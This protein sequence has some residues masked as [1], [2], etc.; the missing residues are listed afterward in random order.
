VKSLVYGFKVIPEN[1]LK[2]T[3]PGEAVL[4]DGSRKS[5]S[6]HFAKG[7]PEKIKQEIL[8]KLEAALK[9]TAGKPKAKKAQTESYS[10]I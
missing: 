6:L 8:H 5:V 7:S 4:K 10:E 2:S 9:E 1:S 3:Q